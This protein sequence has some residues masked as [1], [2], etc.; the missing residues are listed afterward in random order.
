[1][2]GWVCGRRKEVGGA[3]WRGGEAAAHGQLGR[4]ISWACARWKRDWFG[5]IARALLLHL[6]SA[7]TPVYPHLFPCLHSPTL[8]LPHMRRYMSRYCVSARPDI[9]VQEATLGSR[10]R[11]RIPNSV[12]C[13]QYDG[14][15]QALAERTCNATEVRQMWTYDGAVMLF[16][17]AAEVMSRPCIGPEYR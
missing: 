11:L 14:G 15:V 2:V 10:M 13:L 17:H 9:C 5:A 8:A 7:A 16:R 3:W 12:L 6:P 4:V 1:M